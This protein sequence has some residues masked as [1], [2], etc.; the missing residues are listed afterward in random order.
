MITNP[1]FEAVFTKSNIGTSD[2]ITAESHDL[3]ECD[4]EEHANDMTVMN[5]CFCQRRQGRLVLM[6]WAQYVYKLHSFG[7]DQCYIGQA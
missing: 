2:S 4:S 7:I 6:A 3:A 5:D 1:D